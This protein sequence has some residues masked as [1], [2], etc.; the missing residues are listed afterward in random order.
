[1]STTAAP[2][3]DILPPRVRRGRVGGF[4]RRHP[5]IVAGGALIA[6]MV[7][8]AVVLHRVFKRAGWL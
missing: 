2:L 3:P 8:I 6:L 5:T 1:M 7:V 4:V